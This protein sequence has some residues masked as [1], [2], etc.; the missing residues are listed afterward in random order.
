MLAW[1]LDRAFLGPHSRHRRMSS[2]HRV[3]D[4]WPLWPSKPDRNRNVLSSV[5]FACAGGMPAWV[6]TVLRHSVRLHDDPIHSQLAHKRSQGEA[7]HHSNPDLPGVAERMLGL[8]ACQCAAH[9]FKFSCD[10]A[11]YDLRCRCVGPICAGEVMG[12]PVDA[13]ETGGQHPVR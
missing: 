8:Q 2:A 12:E 9:R 13:I 6:E 5:K 10:G 11:G 3:I 1:L 4:Q 7:I